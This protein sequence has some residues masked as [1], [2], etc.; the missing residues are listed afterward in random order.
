MQ[1]L[2]SAWA[3]EG[4]GGAGEGFETPGS[5]EER[6]STSDEAAARPGEAAQEDCQHSIGVVAQEIAE[7]VKRHASN[8]LTPPSHVP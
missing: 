6:R 4:S 2:V 5:P 1:Q 3:A 7:L 8:S